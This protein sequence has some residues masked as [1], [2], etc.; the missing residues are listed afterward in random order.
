MLILFGDEDG[1]GPEDD[2][3]QEEGGD[4]KHDHGVFAAVVLEIAGELVV[5]VDEV[6]DGAAVDGEQ[7]AD[8]RDYHPQ[9]L[10]LCDRLL[11]EQEVQQAD[12]DRAEG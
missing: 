4:Q 12:E 3:Q 7:D 8:E 6:H 1:V 5:A 11:V 9:D 10:L 2:E